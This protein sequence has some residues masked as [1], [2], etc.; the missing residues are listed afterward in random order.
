[1]VALAGGFREVGI[2]RPFSEED[3]WGYF[4]RVIVSV[5]QNHFNDL[6]TGT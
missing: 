2:T 1:V 3:F 6:V 4:R 5:E